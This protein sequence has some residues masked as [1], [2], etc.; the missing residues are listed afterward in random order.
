V[1]PTD[2]TVTPLAPLAPD[3]PEVA[4]LKQA[5]YVVIPPPVLQS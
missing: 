1:Q 4:A 3:T 5:G 2:S